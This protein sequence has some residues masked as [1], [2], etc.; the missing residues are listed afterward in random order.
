MQKLKSSRVRSFRGENPESSLE[1]AELDEYQAPS[2]L[3]QYRGLAIAFAALALFLTVYFIK[4]VVTA[5]RKPPPP[6]Q[7]VYIEVV[8]QK[9]TPPGTQ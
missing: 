7:S 3:V 1:S 5:P 6:V 2:P 9:G 8:P 4:S